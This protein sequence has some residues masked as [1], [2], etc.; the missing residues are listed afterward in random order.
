MVAVNDGIL[1]EAAIYKILKKHTAG[2]P[3]YLPV[4][5]QITR[6]PSPI[7]FPP[8]LFSAT[9]GGSRGLISRMTH[10]RARHWPPVVS[11]RQGAPVRLHLSERNSTAI[12]RSF[13]AFRNP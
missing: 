5:L 4:R 9:S 2:L 13:S 7:P 1:L 12:H 11:R 8:P 10:T 6:F 3:C